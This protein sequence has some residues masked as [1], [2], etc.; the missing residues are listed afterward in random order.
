[1]CT[2]VVFRKFSDGE[3]IAVFPQV[4]NDRYLMSYQHIGQHSNCARDISTFTKPAAPA[5]YNDLLRELCAIGYNDLQVMK[6][7]INY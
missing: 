6:R 2:K 1:M 3:I 7:I 5:E 4:K